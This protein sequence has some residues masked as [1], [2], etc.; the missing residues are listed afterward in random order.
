[1]RWGYARGEEA[2]NFVN[3]VIV[4]YEHYRNLIPE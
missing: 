4:N 3:R 1:V 2:F